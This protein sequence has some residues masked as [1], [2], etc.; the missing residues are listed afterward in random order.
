MK[1]GILRKMEYRLQGRLIRYIDNKLEEGITEESD[2]L[3]KIAMKIIQKETRKYTP[4][5]F[6]KEK[7]I[8]RIENNIYERIDEFVKEWSNVANNEIKKLNERIEL[9]E[10]NI[11]YLKV[12][13]SLDT[14][15]PI[16]ETKN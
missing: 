15:K 2:N 11:Q 12:G 9:I 14:F 1:F 6:T 8:N 5:M 13:K 7:I 10:K 4:Q 16:K 3:G